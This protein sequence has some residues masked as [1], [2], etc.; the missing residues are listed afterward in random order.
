MDVFREESEVE[1]LASVTEITTG[2]V[3]LGGLIISKSG[4]RAGG[5]DVYLVPMLRVGIFFFAEL[6]ERWLPGGGTTSTAIIVC[7]KA[8]AIIQKQRRTV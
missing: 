8:F 1:G 3:G 2:A 4:K 7:L 5:L 6:N